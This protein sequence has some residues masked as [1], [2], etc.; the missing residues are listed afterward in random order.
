MSPLTLSTGVDFEA[1]CERAGLDDTARDLLAQHTEPRAF[2]DALAEGGHFRTAASV[3]AHSLGTREAVIWAWFSARDAAGPSP[4][5]TEQACL[6]AARAWIYEPTDANRFAAFTAAR[7]DRFDSAA[8]LACAAAFCSGG[9]MAPDNMPEV[10]PAPWA[11]AG[12]VRDCVLL[13]AVRGR[14]A[15]T[16]A[17]RYRAFLAEGIRIADR[18][19]AFVTV[20]RDVATTSGTGG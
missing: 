1:I 19:N 15:E 4:G 17:D 3:M 12:A 9:T 13:A 8:S 7:E 6:T 18:T 5:D 14:N 10:L 11:S 20:D 16:S 2:V